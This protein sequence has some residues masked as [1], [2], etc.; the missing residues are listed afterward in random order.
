MPPP[1]CTA[2]RCCWPWASCTPC[3]SRGT[4]GGKPVAWWQAHQPLQVTRRLAG[5]RQQAPAGADVRG[6]GRLDRPPAPRGP[7]AGRAG[8]GRGRAASWSRRPCRSPAPERPRRSGPRRRSAPGRRRRRP[9]PGGA[10]SARAG[11]ADRVAT[12]RPCKPRARQPH[13]R[14]SAVVGTYV[15][16][17]DASP[18]PAVP[19]PA[20][21]PVRR[22]PVD[23]RIPRA[24]HRPRRSTTRSTPSTAGRSGPCPATAPARRSWASPRSGAR[25]HELRL[26]DSSYSAYSAGVQ[27]PP[28]RS[29]A[30][31]A[32][33]AAAR[34]T[35]PGCTTSRRRCR[36]GLAGRL[37]RSGW[38]G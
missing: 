2:G 19:V 3:S 14:R 17:Y 21:R 28:A 18:P 8:Q 37:S 35:P 30:A 23:A 31:G 36:P 20:H 6:A 38:H 11:S 29:A 9:R 16:T 26:V 24:A 4:G 32:D 5:R 10:G 27:R 25:A 1:C 13:L 7:A 15:H 22:A 12:P 33:R 34:G